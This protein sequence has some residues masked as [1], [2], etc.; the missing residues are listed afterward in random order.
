MKK[1][2]IKG[3]SLLLVTVVFVTS[4]YAGIATAGDKE[5]SA[6]G[7]AE[8]FLQDYTDTYNGNITAGTDLYVWSGD[9]SF[10]PKEWLPD[11]SL[12]DGE[13]VEY[14]DGNIDLTPG[15]TSPVVYRI[16][17]KNKQSRYKLY[18]F[19]AV[20][21][22][23]SATAHS[24]DY[25]KTIYGL[26]K[27]KGFSG[28]L[29]KD[30]TKS[31]QTHE[32][33]EE[34]TIVKGTNYYPEFAFQNYDSNAY[35][36]EIHD[37]KL[38]TGKTGTYELIY[39][40]SPIKDAAMNWHEKYKISVVDEPAGNNGMKVTAE[41]NIIHAAVID[42]N[43]CESEVF[44]GKEYN[45]N[46]GVK[47]IIVHSRRSYD[48]YADIEVLKDG[49][50]VSKDDIIDSVEKQ[51]N[52]YVINF[53]KKYDYSGYEVKLSN[54][55][56]LDK[57]LKRDDNCFVGGWESHEN[58]GIIVD[59]KPHDKKK[60]FGTKVYETITNLFSTDVKAAASNVKSWS[61]LSC[62]SGNPDASHT[63]QEMHNGVFTGVT[64]VDGVRLNLSKNKLIDSIED[65]I[66]DYGLEITSTND[67]PTSL[68]LYCSDHG[69]AGYYYSQL[70]KSL[71]TYLDAYLKKDGNTYY[72]TITGE[73]YGSGHQH[74]KGSAKIPLNKRPGSIQINKSTDHDGVVANAKY[75]VYKTKDNADKKKNA[76]F[77]MK[78]NDKGVAKS[79]RAQNEKLTS[80]KTYYVRET[81]APDGTDINGKVIKVPLPQSGKTA[82]VSTSNTPWKVNIKVTKVSDTTPEKPLAGAV[83]T[84]Q[85][86]D[87]KKYADYAKITTGANGEASTGWLYYTKKNNGKWRIV[88]T[89]APK[90]YKIASNPSRDYTIKKAD[91]GKVLDAKYENGKF[92]FANKQDNLYGYL[93]IQKDVTRGIRSEYDLTATFGVY[94]SKADAD[95][96][97]NM[98]T[99][100]R[101][102]SSGWG[103][104][105]AIKITDIDNERRTVYVKEIAWSAGVE[106][107]DQT[108][109]TEYEI[110]PKNTITN[111]AHK[112]ASVSN[113]IAGLQE[114]WWIKLKVKKIKRKSKS[115][116]PDVPLKGATFEFYQWNGSGWTKVDTK[117]TGSGGYAVSNEICWSNVNQGKVAVKEVKSPDDHK[118]DDKTMHIFYFSREDNK[119]T[120]DVSDSFK[121]KWQDTPFGYLSI[122]K[123]ITDAFGK[124][125]TN[126][127]FDD[128]S[129]KITYELL[130]EDKKT[131]VAPASV[132][133]NIKLNADG[134]WQGTKPIEP[135]HYYLREKSLNENIFSNPKNATVEL[136]IY[137]DEM[138]YVDGEKGSA[139]SKDKFIKP[140]DDKY[141][142]F[143][144]TSWD[145]L[146]TD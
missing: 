44:L 34:L 16:T 131:V 5:E 30:Y 129:L 132:Y 70:S 1:N 95:A 123:I 27:S 139:W 119:K 113:P 8:G 96:D 83:F 14:Y 117:D 24:R 71:V 22:K 137:P 4:V 80:G 93:S 142:G 88:E 57:L 78:T 127:K 47:Q 62:L 98:I 111:P 55:N 7:N 53:K 20:S 61:M 12:D 145:N 84:I 120:V 76:L 10:T 37:G 136:W 63:A 43:G 85:Q 112:T 38:D 19:T 66:D 29:P 25:D 15:A 58:D 13:T 48:A 146:V 18:T 102:N 133:G 74:L 79:T 6:K 31:G 116:D 40:V 87:G 28:Y 3:L 11:G 69:A 39:S 42:E 144:W 26:P 51:D 36:A 104:S 89:Q 2:I 91:N 50:A 21:R 103:E 45:L 101:T 140:T 23:T 99:Q 68:Y 138:T 72:V 86:W 52:T 75:S 56:L 134:Y 60:T 65:V 33:E 114:P 115:S 35:V 59:R 92:K 94:D 41:D 106:P 110:T 90:G 135:G 128:P 100:F 141:K 81:T 73:F 118:L 126:W 124:K 97:R 109:V 77:V 105:E 130:Y 121:Q 49:E 143:D 125:E 9:N 67:V 64:V 122:N 32:S 108:K 46:A 107:F 82:K 17:D 54:Q